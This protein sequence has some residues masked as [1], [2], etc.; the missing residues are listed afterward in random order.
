MKTVFLL[1]VMLLAPC[2][3]AADQDALAYLY[4]P[5][6]GERQQSMDRRIKIHARNTEFDAAATLSQQLLDSI[7][8]LKDAAPSTYGQIMINHGI[9]LGA[10]G[11]HLRG[12]SSIERGIEFL[13]ATNNPFD[14][15]LINGL[16]AKGI[17]QLQIAALENAE[18][19]FRR[20]QHITHR[21][22]GVYNEEQLT[23]VS[24]L[25]A[26]NLRQTNPLAADRQQ[27]FSLKTAEQSYGSDS[28]KMLPTL[29]RLGSYFASRASTIPL[30]ADPEFRLR[31]GILFKDAIRMYRQAINIIEINYGVNDLR[32][33]TPLRG[34]ASARLFERTQR[35]YAEVALLRSLEIV[36]SNPNSDLTDRAQARVDL[37]D[38][39]VIT[40]DKK[41][42]ETYLKAWAILQESPKT[43]QL[44]SSLFGTPIRLYPKKSP[45]LYLD[46]TPHAVT[47]EDELF[48]NLQY[49]V[50]ADGRAEEVKVIDGNVPN[51]Q[52]RM[53]RQNLR[54]SRYRPQILDGE[55]VSTEALQDRQLFVV[56]SRKPLPDQNQEEEAD[57]PTEK[58]QPD[59]APLLEKV[60]RAKDLTPSQEAAPAVE[61]ATLLDEVTAK[62]PVEA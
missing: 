30:L 50:S 41:A 48:V 52:V 20:A 5:I 62:T 49:N 37:G 18:D 10:G 21:H 7:D 16:M 9:L 45:V 32:L 1:T 51:E 27:R 56:L 17:G 19:T 29:L 46:R 15:I 36:N 22:K 43:Q 13:E 55:L 54:A 12:L 26:V 47:P 3:S 58:E 24:Y 8:P 31:R 44:A 35:E 40:S 4:E 14:E 2:L 60:P 6:L 28:I 61:D 34:L 33:L 39:Y 11:E 23:I 25:T 38:L 53:L 57:A 42:R 59:E